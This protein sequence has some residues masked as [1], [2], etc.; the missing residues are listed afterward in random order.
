METKCPYCHKNI[1]K[2]WIDKIVAEQRIQRRLAAAEQIQ[3]KLKR[4]RKGQP[5]GNQKQRPAAECAAA[6][7]RS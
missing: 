4:L 2:R 5:D 7:Q 1:H 6:N 3:R